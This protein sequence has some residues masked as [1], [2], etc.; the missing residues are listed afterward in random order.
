M[1]DRDRLAGSE[2]RLVILKMES[3]C[4][5]AIGRGRAFLRA[6]CERHYKN[7]CGAN[8]AHNSSAP[9]AHT[10]CLNAV[11]NDYRPMLEWP[12]P[13]DR[14]KADRVGIKDTLMRAK[15]AFAKAFSTCGPD[16]ARKAVL[17]MLRLYHSDPSRNSDKLTDFVNSVSLM[18]DELYNEAFKKQKPKRLLDYL[19]TIMGVESDARALVS[20]I[21]QQRKKQQ[22]MTRREKRPRDSETGVPAGP[23]L[24]RPRTV[25]AA[26]DVPDLPPIPDLDDDLDELLSAI[27]Q[28]GPVDPQI[29]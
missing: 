20:Q 15:H 28:A 29:F 3:G 6:Y 8:M 27:D 11:L 26:L 18:P 22:Q 12:D 1:I 25:A 7:D 2:S 9:L 5:D 24:Q 19:Q 4:Q 10:M 21:R 14:M 13:K 23:P 16:V 17:D